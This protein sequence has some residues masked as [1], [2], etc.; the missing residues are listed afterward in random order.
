M[1]AGEYFAANQSVQQRICVTA[2]NKN[3]FTHRAIFI[4]FN[5]DAMGG[6]F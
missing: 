2:W 3:A 4:P 5:S 1:D 6:I